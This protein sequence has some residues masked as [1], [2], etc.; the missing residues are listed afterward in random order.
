MKRKKNKILIFAFVASVNITS[1]AQTQDKVFLFKDFYEIVITNHPIAKQALLLSDLAKSEVLIARGHFDAKFEF[2]LTQKYLQGQDQFNEKGR[3]TNYYT[4]IDNG[5]KVPLWFGP[6]I[7]FGFEDNSGRLVNPS[8]FTPSGGLA[9]VGLKIPLIQGMIIDERRATMKQARLMQNIAENER[10][11]QINKVLYS[12]AKEYLDWIFAFQKFNYIK[13]SYQFSQIRFDATKQRASNGDLA[14]IDTLEA[15]SLLQERLIDLQNAENDLQNAQVLVSTFLWTPQNEPL[16]LSPELIPQ[17]D[18]VFLNISQGKVKEILAIQ[19]NQHPELLKLD[20]KLRQYEIEVK[21]A[22]DKLL[23]NFDLDYKYLT[24]NVSNYTGDFSG[25]Y[26][27]NNYKIGL[28]LL[29]PI[30]LR[31]ERGKIE[32]TKI[33]LSQ[34]QFERNLASREIANNI[35]QVANDLE[36]YHLQI[37]LQNKMVGYS[38]SLRD[39][40]IEKFSAGES[41]LFLTNARESKLIDSQI[42][43]ADLKR[44]LEKT[45]FELLY[46]AGVSGLRLE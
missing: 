24:S 37:D 4:Y 38:K 45:K 36:T 29:Q 3:G 34:T 41:S 30:F 14:T 7:Q 46:E 35:S 39:A 31:K 32:M 6:D 18:T 43:L 13:E 2:E 25:N 42:K 11:K 8:N 20:N 28:T 10:I 44:K 27:A 12:A 19:T 5:L 22:R 15:L 23:P 16:E 33:K 40:E 21:L 17:S 1:I 9:Y 26:F